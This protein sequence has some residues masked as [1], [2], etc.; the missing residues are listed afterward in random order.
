[1]VTWGTVC[2][3]MMLMRNESHFYWLRFL[4]GAAEAGFFPGVIL[5]LTYWFPSSRRAQTSALFLLS[6]PFAYATAGP[7]CGVLLNLEGVAG[8][9]GWQWMFL[10]QGL[11]TVLVGVWVF[12]FLDDKPADARWLSAGERAAIE[13]ALAEDRR[14]TT[15][16]LH[17][18]FRESLR[19]PRLWILA[20]MYFLQVT[21][22]YG[23][24]AWLPPIFKSKLGV[25]G[26]VWIGL[27]TAVPYV[28]C[29]VAM[30]AVARSS[31][32]LRERRWHVIA[33]GI[34]AALGMF[35]AAALRDQALA[36]LVAMTVAALATFGVPGPFWSLS[37]EFLKGSSAAGG[38]A[39]INAIGCLGGFVGP[40]VFERLKR[41]DGSMGLSY[42]ALG[43]SFALFA[44]LTW[45]LRF[46]QRSS[47]T[48]FPA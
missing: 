39:L 27:L 37:T 25:E 20:A 31:D 30:I 48:A 21:G 4:L 16:T 17:L 36:C 19:Q 14:G 5:Y 22:F 9:S 40:V 45:T 41:H 13:A 23:L 28:L 8:L 44:L 34:A 46:W 42:L 47:R 7:L 32:R 11:P 2:A 15:A 33:C 24:N 10:G 29:A 35:A 6:M 3:L 38:I 1:M 26:N 18:T 12:F 43:C